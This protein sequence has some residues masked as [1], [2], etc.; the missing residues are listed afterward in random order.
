M[1]LSIVIPTH[2]R[3]AYLK[4]CL[5]ALIA[6]TGCA[7]ECEVTVI[8]DHS[9]QDIAHINS[10]LCASMRV[11][12]HYLERNLGAASARNEGIARCTGEWVAFLD[13]DVCVERDWYDVC[14]KSVS[15]L[16]PEI[17]GLEGRLEAT[18]DGVW[19]KEIEVLSGKSYLTCHIVYRKTTLERIGRFDARFASRYPTCEDHE[20]A[21]RAL[22]WGDILFN[23]HLCAR[24]LPRTVRPLRYLRDA[25]YR[26]RSL[27]DAEFY[28]FWKH[29]DRYHTMRHA[30]TFWGTYKNIVLFHT[31]A[32]LKRRQI[33]RLLRHPFQSMTLIGASILEQSWALLL[34]GKYARAFCRHP[35]ALFRDHISEEPTRCAWM[36]NPG[37]DLSVL[38][39]K[40]HLLRS[41]LFPLHREPVYSM[42]PFFLKLRPR[43][44][45][46]NLRIFLRI[47]DVFLSDPAG[48]ELLCDKMAAMKI[49]Y[50]AG[51]TGNDLGLAKHNQVKARIRQS[52]GIIALH[53]FSHTGRFGPYKS[54]ILQMNIPAIAAKLNTL[55]EQMFPS[56]IPR[57]FIPPY[58]AV[59][60]DQ[61]VFLTNY[62]KVICGG[63]ETARFTDYF[64]GP[65]A[66][67]N[68]SWYVPSFFPFYNNASSMLQSKEFRWSIKQNGLACITL[69]MPLEAQDRFNGLVDLLNRIADKIMPWEYF[70][71]KENA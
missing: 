41:L 63:P 45:S 36:L 21:V 70:F 60:R 23:P 51:I 32:T 35:R 22:L 67:A 24:H 69:H 33:S 4:Q 30:R 49:G 71:K 27:L 39:L 9:R 61:I 68:D 16:S 62:F 53:G 6:S 14:V 57:I 29:R 46:A 40:P 42:V 5:E 37:A 19:D 20:L 38:Q 50:C 56:E 18:G 66:L 54:E 28:F 3:S 47:D 65:L 26:I 1:L 34:F 55:H 13:D 11:G 10:S 15:G 59:S 7:A 64:S 25:F 43:S 31:V 48:V 58:N 8:D 52:G 44:D 17:I 12:Y 2:N